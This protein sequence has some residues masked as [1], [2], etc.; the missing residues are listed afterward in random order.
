MTTEKVNDLELVK[1]SDYF[2]AG[3][4]PYYSGLCNHGTWR[5]Q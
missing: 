1:L 2:L 4:I 3:E 5:N